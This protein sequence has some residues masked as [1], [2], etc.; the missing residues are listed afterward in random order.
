M[1][2]AL[3]FMFGGHYDTAVRVFHEAL[4]TC[5]AHGEQWARSY[6]LS[7]LAFT[8][9][10]RGEPAEATTHAREAMRLKL[11]SG[12]CSARR[13]ASSCS[14]GSRGRQASTSARPYCLA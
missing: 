8:E 2:Y 9:W 3:A 12:T 14:P 4:A 6:V 10:V 11:A 5:D 7:N 13:S 1:G